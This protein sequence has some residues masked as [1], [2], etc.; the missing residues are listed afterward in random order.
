[1]PDLPLASEEISIPLERH[2]FWRLKIAFKRPPHVGEMVDYAGQS[3]LGSL[4]NEIAGEHIIHYHILLKRVQGER[5]SCF[6]RVDLFVKKV[7]VY[8]CGKVEKVFIIWW[9]QDI[10]KCSSWP[11]RIMNYP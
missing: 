10:V 6:E 3:L 1:V 5:E 7:P 8:R 2:D 11:R 4:M 9:R